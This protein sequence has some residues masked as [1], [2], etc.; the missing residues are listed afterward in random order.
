MK[1]RQDVMRA[2][3]ELITVLLILSGFVPLSWGAE[4]AFQTATDE[5]SCGEVKV[6]VVT[7]CTDERSPQPDC[8]RQHFVFSNQETGA[9]VKVQGSG[10]LVKGD[11]PENFASLDALAVHWACVKGKAGPYVLIDYST[12]G[13]CDSCQWHELFDLKGKRLATSQVVDPYGPDTR[14][15]KKWDSLGLPEP[16]PGKESR[17]KLRRKNP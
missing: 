4:P 15:T 5:L 6:K 12:G 2:A 14:F 7:T 1:S 17:I 9:S 11:P 10:R 16:W 8:I 3:I 13:R